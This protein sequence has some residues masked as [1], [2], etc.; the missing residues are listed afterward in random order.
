MT[1]NT[2]PID[3]HDLEGACD[4]SVKNDMHVQR[5]MDAQVGEPILVDKDFDPKRF[6]PKLAVSSKPSSSSV[7]WGF[8]VSAETPKEM[9]AREIAAAQ[10][11]LDAAQTKQA[12]AKAEFQRRNLE[13]K[14]QRERLQALEG[15]QKDTLARIK[16]QEKAIRIHRQA[17]FGLQEAGR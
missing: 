10:T 2:Q 1:A 4:D 14:S 16:A 3:F 11:L 6:P 17:V 12:D 15:A 7:D 8:D 5:Y 13:I 9:F